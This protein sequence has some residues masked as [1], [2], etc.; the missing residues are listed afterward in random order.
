MK[1]VLAFVVVGMVVSTAHADPFAVR[2][3]RPDAPPSVTATQQP[4]RIEQR[5]EILDPGKSQRRTATIIVAGG[6]ALYVSSLI[7]SLSM[8]SR[9]DDAIA[10]LDSGEGDL[11]AAV[12]DANHARR[13]AQVAGTG[14]F[15]AG[16]VAIGVGAYLYFTAPIKIRREHV[17]IVPSVDSQGVGLSLSGGF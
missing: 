8:K 3:P 4:A 6:G 15:A 13:I 16:A 12:D 14:L 1:S 10:R 5:V 11:Q 2:N 17:A 7:V 9:Y